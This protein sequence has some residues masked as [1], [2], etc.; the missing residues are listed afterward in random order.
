LLFR[1][2]SEPAKLQVDLGDLQNEKDRLTNYLQ[3]HLKV[4]ASPVKD[5]LAVD[6]GNVTLSDLHHAVKKFIY[7][8]GHSATHYISIEGA[9]VKINR[10]KGHEKKK[11][12]HDRG[13]MHQSATQ[14][15]GL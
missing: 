6:S 7:S 14:S 3:L 2:K 4:T 11:E 8:T 10:F 12:K 1:H 5:K 9:T 13:S 15:W